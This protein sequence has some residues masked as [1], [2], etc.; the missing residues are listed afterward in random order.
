MFRLLHSLGRLFECTAVSLV[1][2]AADWLL[3]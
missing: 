2:S 1:L 3:R